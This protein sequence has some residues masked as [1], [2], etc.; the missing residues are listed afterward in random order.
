M[1]WIP[2]TSFQFVLPMERFPSRLE[3]EAFKGF[4]CAISLCSKPDH[5]KPEFQVF[6]TM[7]KAQK[8][9]ATAPC[10]LLASVFSASLD[11]TAAV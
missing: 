10:L 2:E 6:T 11:A 8:T 7:A 9:L 5:K 3:G 4:R 1:A